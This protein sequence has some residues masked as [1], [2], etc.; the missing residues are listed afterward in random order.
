L[1]SIPARFGVRRA[2]GLARVF[3]VLALGA[4]AAV[5]VAAS[6]HAVY[7]LGLGVVAGV[8]VVEHRLVRADDL[9]KIGVAFLNANGVIS[10]LYFGV[11][12]AAL[13]LGK[14]SP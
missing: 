8:L 14:T 10:I 7:F 1:F 5:G 11:V 12:L 9:S 2:L 13:A 3:H 6:L 4:M